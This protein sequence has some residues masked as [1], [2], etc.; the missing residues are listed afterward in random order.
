MEQRAPGEFSPASIFDVADRA[1]VSPSTVSR[2]LRGLPNVAPATRERVARAAHELFYVASPA[3]SGLASGRTTTVGIV[4]PFLSRW[5]FMR[6]VQG[7]EEVIRA[8]GYDVLLHNLGD[9]AGRERFFDR[10]PLNRKV[11]GIVLV[12]VTVQ[13]HEQARLQALGVPVTVVG[14][15]ALGVGAVGIDDAA[16]VR[17]AVRHL[18]HLGHRDIGML[19][20][21]AA[22][23]LN[24]AVPGRRR[25]TFLGAIAE[26]GLVTK[27]E[28][29][30]SS[31]WGI[32]GGARATERLLSSRR[33]PTALFAESDEV[34]FGALRTLRL[35][36][37]DVP[38]RMSVIGFD[39]HEMASVVNLTTVAQPVDAQGAAA[40][41]LLIHAMLGHADPF[42]RLALP[43]Q[44]VIRGSTA[45]PSGAGG[46]RRSPAVTH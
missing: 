2:A 11:D 10:L 36:G 26:A 7:A 5:F 39:D 35:A 3:A 31:D 25:T 1:G 14:G 34:A 32:E 37:L 18:V 43:T 20:G 27:P 44:L 30:V 28:W 13:P 23:G 8:A 12:D 40:A 6:V 45:P 38:R 21:D 16:G 41:R 4:V 33:V 17:M 29:V 42:A 22:T 19:G 24:F 46:S 15:D 9:A